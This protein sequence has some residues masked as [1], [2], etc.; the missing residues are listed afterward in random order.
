MT[1]KKAKNKSTTFKDNLTISISLTALIVSITTSIIMYRANYLESIRVKSS[2]TDSEYL[3]SKYMSDT[4]YSD[5]IIYTGNFQIFNNSSINTTIESIKLG[6]DDNSIIL[7]NFYKSQTEMPWT[8]NSEDF[9]VINNQKLFP[10]SIESNGYIE[11][12]FV[13]GFKPKNEISAILTKYKNSELSNYGFITAY[14]LNR[15][16]IRNSLSPMGN[17]LN[18]IDSSKIIQLISTKK[19][20]KSGNLYS[21]KNTYEPYGRNLMQIEIKTAKEKLFRYEYDLEAQ[22]RWQKTISITGLSLDSFLELDN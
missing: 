8:F 22:F 9:S 13:I 3:F 16:L 4:T 21:Y 12:V 11:M 17:I 19:G 10:L 2:L 20:F 15:E 6:F 18:E 1:K 5:A 14:D 7:Y